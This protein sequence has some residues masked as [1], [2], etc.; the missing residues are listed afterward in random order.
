MP[1]Q[2]D[3]LTTVSAALKGE[4]D[5]TE[6]HQSLIVALETGH[7]LSDAVLAIRRHAAAY[8]AAY[9]AS[10]AAISGRAVVATGPGPSHAP[11]TQRF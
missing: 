5:V 9:D 6:L 4:G 11:M 7:G 10:L 3:A 1:N 8:W 2:N